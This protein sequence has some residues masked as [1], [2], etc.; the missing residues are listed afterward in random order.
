MEN[1][2]KKFEE[3][4][5]SKREKELNEIL[6]ELLTNLDMTTDKSER[7]SILKKII[8][9]YDT[10]RTELFEYDEKDCLK[11]KEELACIRYENMKKKYMEENECKSWNEYQEEETKNEEMEEER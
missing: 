11:K 4:Q 6:I 5:D 9:I 2:M 7:L 10:L 3:N 8:C 1:W